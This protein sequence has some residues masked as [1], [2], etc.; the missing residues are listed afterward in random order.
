MAIY[1]FYKEKIWKLE[2]KYIDQ[3]EEYLAVSAVYIAINYYC[4]SMRYELSELLLL[5]SKLT[6]YNLTEASLLDHDSQ[7]LIMLPLSC[8]VYI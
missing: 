7:V 1:V 6:Q 4:T 8:T 5:G 3:F 2:T